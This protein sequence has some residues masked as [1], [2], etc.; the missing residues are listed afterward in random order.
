MNFRIHCCF[1]NQQWVM[2]ML[3]CFLLGGH[4]AVANNDKITKGGE[5]AAMANTGL[6]S[7]DVFA[8]FNNQAGLA[9]ITTPTL[10]LYAEN[11]F[12]LDAL[13]SYT[14]AA[15]LPTKSGNFGIGLNYYGNPAYN[16]SVFSIAYGRLLSKQL[17]IGTT[18][19]L[20]NIVVEGYGNSRLLTFGFGAQYTLNDRLKIGGHVYNPIHTQASD[21]TNKPYVPTIM[22]LGIA[23]YP[24]KNNATSITLEAEKNIVEKP[25]VK[26][27]F[28][29]LIAEKIAI[30]AG[31]AS[32][33]ALFLFGIAYQTQQFHVD[34]ATSYHS[35]LGYSPHMSLVY[36]LGQRK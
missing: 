21:N 20:Q 4:L 23:Y 28:S 1:V 15:A 36:Q 29:H 19:D 12:F 6:L 11:R 9:H 31:V 7:Q 17:S 33:S 2:G 8:V 14:L 24:A 22:R 27:G 13:S 25:M 30:R 34:I 10:A 32:N 18:I 35:V 3:L 16:E 5:S 26:V